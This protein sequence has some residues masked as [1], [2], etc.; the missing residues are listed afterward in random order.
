MWMRCARVLGDIKAWHNE[1]WHSQYVLA[2]DFNLKSKTRWECRMEFASIMCTTARD[3]NDAF[4]RI[5]TIFFFLHCVCKK[6]KPKSETKAMHQK[7][8]MAN[9]FASHMNHRSSHTRHWH[10]LSR[11]A[12]VHSC[13]VSAESTSIP[14]KMFTETSWILFFFAFDIGRSNELLRNKFMLPRRSIGHSQKQNG[15]EKREERKKKK[16]I[17]KTE[18]PYQC[19]GPECWECFFRVLLDAVKC[20]ESEENFKWKRKRLQTT[21]L[22]FVCS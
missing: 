11:F 20:K 1:L 3:T 4:F 17:C 18:F 6:T 15:K 10:A 2:I 16:Q 7:L 5:C 12:S 9:A 21:S 8:Q 13:I 14:R 22:R 19:V